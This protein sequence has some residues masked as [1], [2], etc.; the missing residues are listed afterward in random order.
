MENKS[1]NSWL[2]EN[3]DISEIVISQFSAI[4]SELKQIDGLCN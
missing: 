2:E 3:K 1:T 4:K